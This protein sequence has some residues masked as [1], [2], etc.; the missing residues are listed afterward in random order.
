MA[1]EKGLRP[2]CLVWSTLLLMHRVMSSQEQDKSCSPSRCGIITNIRNP[3]RL[4]ND[5][6]KC[7][8]PKYEL[9]CENNITLLPLK[10][11]AYRVLGINYND[12]TIRIV[13]PGLQEGNCSSFPRYFLSPSNFSYYDA[14]Y[15]AYGSEPIFKQVVYLK[16]GDPVRG[17]A[18]YVDTA[19]CVNWESKGEGGHL[20]A[21]A[22]DLAAG[23]FKSGCR[24]KM[25]AA[26][27]S[28][29]E[30]L[31]PGGI[32][33]YADI[34]TLLSYGFE[35]DWSSWFDQACAALPCPHNNDC[36]FGPDA[37]TLQC[38][39]RPTNCNSPMA[40]D[41]IGCPHL[42]KT[43]IFAEDYIYGIYKGFRQIVKMGTYHHYSDYDFSLTNIGI[44]LGIA[45]GRVVLPVITTRFLCGIIFLS[46]LLIYTCRRRHLSMY[47]DIEDFIRLHNFIPI[48]YSYKE[49]KTMTKGFKN[50][51]GEGG[52][53]TVYKGTLRSGPEVAVKMLGKSKANGQEFIN[54][55]ATI[56]RIHHFN[57]VHLV[58]FCLEGTKRALVYEFMP[59]GSLD[60]YIFSKESISLSY[61]KIYEIS[62]G[63][64]YG[65]AYLHHGCDMQILHFDI[66]PHNILLD[67]SFT[68]KISDF[69]LA[70]L[71]DIDDSIVTLTAARGTIGYMAP[72]LFYKNIGGVSY[73]ADVYSFGML[74][75]EMASRRR[76]LNPHAEH[77]SQ[78]YFPLW[79]Y[80]QFDED[81]DMKMEDLTEEE[82]D[83]AK[84]MFI[85]ALW[86]IQL[87][88]TN[89]PSM[90]KVIQMLE[91]DDVNSIEMPP[92]PSLYSSE[93]IL[94]DD[95]FDSGQT[96]STIS[97]HSHSSPDGA[98]NDGS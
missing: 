34:H 92:R 74:L 79:I 15:D 19:P 58:G 95:I 53:G 73:K 39:P 41:N 61:H 87:K 10:N 86:C 88:P 71:Y 70:R 45:T 83:L 77:S 48:R 85:I 18:A 81:K 82:K 62:L 29:W 52:F 2:W 31:V 3:F 8:D 26:I 32:K 98:A 17:D 44:T 96:T 46:V 28:D 66:K 35:I 91:A 14:A 7:G 84:R 16:C 6:A 51:L 68:P 25:V 36:S 22:G 27:A 9:A 20:Y 54:E 90:N 97:S 24:V 57:V 67:E 59:K 23:D 60:K 89:R 75:M 94:M 63:V 50:K 40:I 65:I 11:G 13:D 33:S 76:N 93:T 1:R 43:R 78:L 4:R 38:L 56:G 69:G 64:A 30:S 55:V 47:E 49:L 72:E 37:Q 5:P 12:F 21:V 42:P 80:D